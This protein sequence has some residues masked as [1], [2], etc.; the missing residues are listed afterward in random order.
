MT[1]RRMLTVRV[2][3]EAHSALHDFCT[4]YGITLTAWIEAVGQRLIEHGG[5]DASEALKSE[6][7][8]TVRVAR[9]VDA[10]R[11]TRSTDR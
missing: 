7:E 8:H 2:S 11:R 6:V 10:E 9:L 1:E 4:S 3:D 5:S